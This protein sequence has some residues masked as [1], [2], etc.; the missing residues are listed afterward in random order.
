VGLDREAK[1]HAVKP[2]DEVLLPVTHVLD[3][4]L[5]LEVVSKSAELTA[6]LYV[7]PTQKISIG[8]GQILWQY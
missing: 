7:K 3:S 5:K 6:E 2:G 1:V 4:D 8:G